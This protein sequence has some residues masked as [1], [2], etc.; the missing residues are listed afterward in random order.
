MPA[1]RDQRVLFM[2][3]RPLYTQ[4][5]FQPAESGANFWP[6]SKA[7]LAIGKLFRSVFRQCNGSRASGACAPRGK[8]GS[9]C[10]RRRRGCNNHRRQ[11]SSVIYFARSELWRGGQLCALFDAAYNAKPPLDLFNAPVKL[12]GI[13]C[14]IYR[15]GGGGIGT[16]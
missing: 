12:E 3:Q 10:I 16:A 1:E 4:R 6:R 2:H 14:V 9:R 8:T 15:G 13:Q 5:S 11:R 7:I